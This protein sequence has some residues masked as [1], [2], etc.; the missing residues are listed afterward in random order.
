MT[1]HELESLQQALTGVIAH[2]KEQNDRP[3]DSG[4]TP[5]D[6]PWKDTQAPAE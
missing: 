6:S 5:T 4:E 2:A 1:V 3:D